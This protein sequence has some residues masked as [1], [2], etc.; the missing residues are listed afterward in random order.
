MRDKVFWPVLIAISALSLW[1]RTGFPAFD[2]GNSPYDD[3]LFI[4]LAGHL[5]SGRWLGPYDQLTLAKGMFYPLF[6]LVA[7]I[8]SI[9]LK[10]AEQA[11]YLA[12]CVLVAKYVFDRTNRRW[13]AVLLFAALAFNPVLWTAE[14]SRVM[15][16]GIYLSL[17]LAVVVLTLLI[18]FPRFT[19]ARRFPVVLTVGL[20]L[21]GGAFWLTREE[22]VWILPALFVAFAGMMFQLRK[23]GELRAYLAPFFVT[24]ATFVTVLT[25]VAGMNAYYYG[26]FRLN[27][28]K[29]GGFVK[30]YGAISRVKPAVW[31][32]YVVFPGDVRQ[33]VYAVSPAARELESR[34]D[35]PFAITLR[36]RGCEQ[37]RTADCP[38]IL[39]GWFL[40]VLRGIA[41]D[42]GH[43]E[44][45]SEA[46]RYYFQLAKEIN[47][48]C[49]EKKLDCL[50]ERTT[51]SPP[52]RWNYLTDAIE[53]ALR[54]MDL[55]LAMGDGQIGAPLSQGEDAIY[56][57]YAAITGSVTPKAS[58]PTTTIRGWAGS[59]STKPEIYV[60]GSGDNGAATSVEILEDA[61]IAETHPGLK[62]VR[63][64]VTSDCPV[65]RCNMIVSGSD[66]RSQ[67]PFAGL[68]SGLMMAGQTQIFIE[69]VNGVHMRS[70]F[71]DPSE[72]RRAV[73]VKI[74][75][76]ITGIYHTVV[77]PLS[78]L[79]IFGTLISVLRVSRRS[80]EW[81][82]LV[83][84]LASGVAVLSRIA[85]L[86]YIE[87]SSFPAI[88]LLYAAPASPFV[89]VF[90]VMGT[91]VGIS[92]LSARST[93]E[94][95]P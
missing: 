13:I 51:I 70:K 3:T 11:V 18:A 15:R 33:R 67:I 85:A 37:T 2:L 41:A 7:F 14:L 30:A 25:I 61:E 6:I 10:V 47:D 24:V 94:H 76:M 40:W 8:T 57:I 28:L 83:F 71:G 73:Q 69:D 26:V 35:G 12:A 52:F 31:R 53:P 54:G 43:Y 89:I 74:A 60:S 38:E 65:D 90:A 75:K 79:A 21:A 72:M 36:Q 68:Q 39:A 64:I 80:T 78:L 46:D 44:S 81:P 62:I 95:K 93:A 9:P 50:P 16:D 56:K 92:S 88:N 27:D 4:K 48:A 17:S 58:P 22:G 32:R 23:R 87:V 34:L 5:G 49:N 86:A 59:P 84:V 19:S 45:A 91:Y 42:N 77:P 82:L 63:F 66:D 1:M 55:V 29:S 20:G